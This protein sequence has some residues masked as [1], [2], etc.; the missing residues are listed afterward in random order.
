VKGSNLDRAE[1]Q[2]EQMLSRLEDRLEVVES[3]I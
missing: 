2:L 1:Y 3:D